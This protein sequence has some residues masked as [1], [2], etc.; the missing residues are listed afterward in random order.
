M[1]YGVSANSF[2][3]SLGL[4]PAVASASVHT[5]EACTTAVSG[6]SHL[7]LGNVDKRL[8]KQLVLPGVLGAVTGA[9][10]LTAVPGDL[11]KPFVAVYL[12][13]MGVLILVK[14]LHKPAAAPPP[15]RLVPL[16][17]VGGFMDAVGGGGWG[18]IVT[19]TLVARGHEPRFVIGS[20]N[21]AEFFLTVAQALTFAALLG[22]AHWPM[23][24]GLMLG[25]VVAAPLA[26]YV[27]RRLP[28]RALMIV[29]GI[30][31]IVLSARTLYL[32]LVAR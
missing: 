15:T 25:G 14:A 8:L 11:I 30:L 9:Y 29:V 22:L 17:L 13:G 18:P 23:V 21:A 27:C 7:K 28:S 10:I 31:V 19:S 1:A 12:L 4:P 2:L 5:A 24:L 20:V 32:S 16:G 3:L 26:A 6:L